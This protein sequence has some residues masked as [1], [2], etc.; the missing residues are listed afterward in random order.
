MHTRSLLRSVLATAPLLAVA[1]TGCEPNNANDMPEDIALRSFNNCSQLR[2]Y[3]EEVVLEQLIM[4][5]Y[6]WGWYGMME[7]GDVAAD[8]PTSNS[9]G[10]DDY[11]TTNVQEEGVDEID[12]VK[13]NGTEI[14][15]AEGQELQI[16]KSWPAEDAALLATLDMGEW[17][18]G[19][20]LRDDTLL[21]LSW[22]Y[23]EDE[24]FSDRY[25]GGTRVS[26]VDVSD[27]TDPEVT[28]NVDIE[29]WLADGRLIDEDAYLVINTWLPIPQE[30]WELLWDENLGLPE[31]DWDADEEEQ[32]RIRDE[33]RAI[34]SPLVHDIVSDLDISD[35]MPLYRDQEVGAADADVV[36]LLQCNDVY[37]PADTAQFSMMSIVHI[38]LDDGDLDATGVMADGWTVYAS[39]DNL[40]VA[41]T[42]WWWWWGWGDLD[43]DTYIHKF[44]LGDEPVYAAAGKVDG[45]LLDQFS[46]S[47]YDGYLRVA[48]TETDWWWGT[49]EDEGGNLVTVLEDQDGTLTE[50]GS[51]RD[52]AP[53]EHITGVRMMGDVGY[54]VTFEWIDPL[55][56]VDL[57]DPTDPELKGELELPGFATYM[58]PLGDDHLISV[59]YAGTPQGTITGVAINL[60]DVSDENN[61]TLADH[62]AVDSDDWSYSEALWDHHAFTY[63]RDVLSI[64]IYTYDYDEVYGYWEGFSGLLVLKITADDGIEE[65]GRVDH[66]DLVADSECYYDYGCYDD[67]WYAW[68]RRSVYIEDNLFSIS[69]YGMKVNELMDPDVEIAKVLYHPAAIQ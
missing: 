22:F 61:P 13:T 3:A 42:S 15:H 25:W 55:W 63:H 64:P 60:Y 8:A 19:L 6:G 37:R 40:Y 20:F 38:D 65:L 67:Y 35:L 9:D 45:W 10:P 48:S 33:A 51:V 57:S 21:V 16:V 50:V 49:G 44:E 41:Q 31:M 68:M 59:G 54:V 53:G 26:F 47:E 5:R 11:T 27:P 18:R 17:I 46:M 4:S 66:K 69:N 62:F 1:L 52:I 39:R 58:H 7:D 30:A 32:D 2:D 24:A 56:V 23:D 43:L 36:P 29:G 34:L 28:R 12:I 14:F